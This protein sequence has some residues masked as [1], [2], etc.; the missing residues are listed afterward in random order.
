MATKITI[1][2]DEDTGVVS[3]FSV[4]I[5]KQD[6]T[7]YEI[8]EHTLDMIKGLTYVTPDTDEIM[9]ALEDVTNKWIH[10]GRV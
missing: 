3:E 8:V 9:A 10:E 2:H 5:N 6:V 7:W 4:T 1:Q